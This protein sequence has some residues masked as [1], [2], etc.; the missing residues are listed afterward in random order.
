VRA[1]VIVVSEAVDMDW[2]VRAA[3][4][5]VS[6]A[7]DMDWVVRA[8]TVVASEALATEKKECHAALTAQL[9]EKVEQTNKQSGGKY[10]IAGEH[11]ALVA[12]SAS[13]AEPSDI[14]DAVVTLDSV[15]FFVKQ[16]H[17]DSVV[18]L[19]TGSLPPPLLS[20]VQPAGAPDSDVV[21]R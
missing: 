19:V 14:P 17:H 10:C 20:H 13:A 2:V 8:A 9:Q 3:V 15:V 7:V 21:Y 4:I 12:T 6:E 18:A 5:V 11:L 1:A 16:R